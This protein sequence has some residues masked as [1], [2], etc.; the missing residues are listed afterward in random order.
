MAKDGQQEIAPHSWIHYCL[1][2]RSRT[3]RNASRS[4]ESED[5]Y[6]HIGRWDAPV[7][8]CERRKKVRSPFTQSLKKRMLDDQP[9]N[10]HW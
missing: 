7:L 9:A 4:A 3:I 8:D 5:P 1:P 10:P 6:F 2:E